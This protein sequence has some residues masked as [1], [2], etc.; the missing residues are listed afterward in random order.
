M[1]ADFAWPDRQD[2]YVR[3]SLEFL[4]QMDSEEWRA[5]RAEIVQHLNRLLDD[6]Y[7]ALQAEHLTRDHRG[8][9]SARYGWRYRLLYKLCGECRLQGD[10]GRYT[11]ACCLDSGL[12]QT[13]DNTINVLYLSDHYGDTPQG[14]EIIEPPD[15]AR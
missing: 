11:L 14:F 7:L 12:D 15:E 9:R 10:Q 3:Y 5:Q 2:W 4:E 6:P 8:L 13:P 1:P